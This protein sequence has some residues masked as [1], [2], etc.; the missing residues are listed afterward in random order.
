MEFDEL[1]DKVNKTRRKE[2]VKFLHEN[3]SEQGTC[4][5]ERIGGNELTDSRHDNGQIILLV[6]CRSI[7]YKDVM[8]V[9]SIT[10]TLDNNM[11]ETFSKGF[12]RCNDLIDMMKAAGG[13]KKRRIDGAHAGGRPVRTLDD[14]ERQRIDKERAEG[15]SINSIAK[16]MGISNRLVM[17]HCKNISKN[18]EQ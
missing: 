4:I 9:W 13:I 2:L 14:T 3:Y 6:I 16:G 10:D 18:N 15:K 8:N 17:K 11:Q 1:L 12:I 5:I 7:Y